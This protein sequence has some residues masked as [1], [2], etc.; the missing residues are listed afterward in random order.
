M[1]TEPGTDTV[2]APLMRVLAGE[3]TDEEIAALVA[4]LAVGTFLLAG[5]WL[6]AVSVQ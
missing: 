3:P 2:A 1:S 5:Q 4:V 6:P